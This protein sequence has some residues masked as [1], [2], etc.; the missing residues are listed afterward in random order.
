MKLYIFD[1]DGTLAESKQ[2][3][4]PEVIG[5]L[6]ELAINNHVA[7]ISG[8]AR[9]QF[10]EQLLSQLS[11][12]FNKKNLFLLPTSG[13]QLLDWHD[14]F[15]EWVPR[16]SRGLS[17][18]DAKKIISVIKKHTSRLILSGVTDQIE[19]R[20]SQ[21]TFSA[22]GQHAA[23]EDKVKWDKTG[24]KKA[25]LRNMIA[26]DLPEF[27][28]RTGG[29]TSIDVTLKGIDKAYGVG[30]LL[31]SKRA[32]DLSLGPQRG[33]VSLTYDQIIFFGDALQPGGNDHCVTQLK[34]ITCIQVDDPSEVIAKIKESDG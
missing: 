20:G 8:A 19:N 30:M 5:V 11:T 2:R 24:A 34:G 14:H 16:Y 18:E 13:A 25:Y 23:L 4:T 33:D 31:T 7:I 6:E 28:V 32:I 22:L 29:T 15:K 12:T 26:Q 1:L 17:D 9:G 10:E 3:V 21:I 27:E